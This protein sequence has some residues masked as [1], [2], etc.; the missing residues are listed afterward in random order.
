MAITAKIHLKENDILGALRNFFKDIL[1]LEDI[2]AILVPQHLPMKNMVM[3]TLVTD[4]D[5][6]SG[7]DPLAPAFAMNAA[8]IVSRLTRKPMGGKI[9]AVLRPCEIRAFVELAK[10]KQGRPDDIIL[11]GIDCLGAFQ[12]QDY[13]QYAGPNGAESTLRFL[14]TF[15]DGKTTEIEGIDLSTACKACEYPVAASADIQ[16][17]LFGV[18]DRRSFSGPV[19]NRGRNEYVKSAQSC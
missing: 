18:G 3:P 13:F 5:H 7:V 10:L 11:I 19:A 9:A 17:G 14:N 6:L 4:P 1:E 2:R 12:N 16:I 8:K 15:I